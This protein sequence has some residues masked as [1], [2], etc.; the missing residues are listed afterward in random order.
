MLR[1]IAAAGFVVAVAT[2]AQA[3]T[4]APVPQP[5]GMIAQ[6]RLGCGPIRT[7]ELM[8]SAWPEA[9]SS[10][11]LDTILHEVATPCSICC[12]CRYWDARKKLPIR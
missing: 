6:V 7:S 1:L 9:P 4:P 3:I 10:P 8:V 5:D 12:E 11:L 2:S